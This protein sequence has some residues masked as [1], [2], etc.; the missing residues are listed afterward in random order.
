MKRTVVCE[1]VGL[2]HPDK[3]V[4]QISDA[5][6]DAFLEKDP[7]TRAGIEVMMKDNIV[8]LGGEV[9]S[10]AQIDYEHIVRITVDSVDYPANHHLS[11]SDIKVIN[12]IGKQSPEISHSVDKEDWV[13]WWREITIICIKS[14][15]K[16]NTSKS[17]NWRRL[18]VMVS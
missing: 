9:K 15:R 6:L 3:V 16:E 12:L 2:G 4:D 14:E 7:N 10:E 1:Y 17:V 5:L 11:G 18:T 8:V 13:M